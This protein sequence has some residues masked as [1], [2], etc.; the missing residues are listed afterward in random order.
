MMN[1][2]ELN[3][4]LD[5]S[6]GE[7]V[8][9]EYMKS[10]IKNVSYHDLPGTTLMIC[11]IKLDNDFVITGEAACVDPANFKREIG[12][13]VSYDRAFAQ[14]WQFFGFLLAEK[15]FRSN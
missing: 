15:R 8:T 2:D 14:L 12:E 1:D 4:A 6:P 5:A 13:K 10:R 7:R 11:A 9:A 3:A